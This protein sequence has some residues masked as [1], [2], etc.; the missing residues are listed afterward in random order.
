MN[1]L[2]LVIAKCDTAGNTHPALFFGM[3]NSTDF[4]IHKR[5]HDCVSDFAWRQRAQIKKSQR[6]HPRTIG[7]KR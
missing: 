4:D 5:R 7:G 1:T 3:A 2:A 6:R